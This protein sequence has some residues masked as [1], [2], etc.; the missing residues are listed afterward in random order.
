MQLRINT[1]KV[2]VA[3]EDFRRYIE[4]RSGKPFEG[5]D[6]PFLIEDEIG[7]KREI[8]EEARRRLALDRWSDWR[9]E[10]GEILEATRQACEASSNLLVHRYGHRNSSSGALYKVETPGEIRA[11]ENEL[12][13][14]FL[15]GSLEPE[16]FGPRFD[17]LANYLRVHRLGARWAFMSYLAFLAEP[18]L[19][20]PIRSSRF[21]P[22]LSYYGIDRQ[23]R[24]YVT[25][26]RYRLL[27]T[28]AD[29]LR[30]KLPGFESADA[31][32]IQSYMWVVAYRI[33]SSDFGQHIVPS[34]KLSEA[35]E[36]KRRVDRAAEQERI[37][38]RGEMWVYD[39]EC[40]RLKEGPYPELASMV[41]MVSLEDESAGYD[42][43]SYTD[44]GEE[45]HIEI[46]TTTWSR[47]DDKGFWLSES[48]R[49]QAE[50]DPCWRLYRVTDIDAS[51]QCEDLGNLARNVA[52]GWTLRPSNWR[53]SRDPI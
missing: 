7:Y 26:E 49:A 42:I 48:E 23:I 36:L 18:K 34:P 45:I 22:L 13:T 39:R 20:F 24:G 50:Q 28:L 27:L 19:Y 3:H 30:Q 21:D 12:C 31:I 52:E 44:H 41:R 53:V 43:Q 38:L 47:A 25:W 17:G 40:Q 6:N 15:E 2:A 35:E 51:P 4:H 8:C 32:E 9:G 46:K 14:F 1:A 37:G 33:T 29:T 5:F 10:T 11:L 16:S